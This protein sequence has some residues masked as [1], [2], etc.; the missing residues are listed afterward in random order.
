MAARLVRAKEAA[1]SSTKNEKSL[2]DL[3]ASFLVETGAAFNAWAD[4]A[5]RTGPREHDIYKCAPESSR[6]SNEFWGML[7]IQ[8]PR[9]HCKSARHHLWHTAGNRIRAEML[10]G[11]YDLCQ[12]SDALH[13]T[14]SVFVQTNPAQHVGGVPA[15]PAVRIVPQSGLHRGPI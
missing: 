2:A 14:T 8:V 11:L 3:F 7:I 9:P 13:L 4:A 1:G 6:D 15:V 10:S 12:S 5:H